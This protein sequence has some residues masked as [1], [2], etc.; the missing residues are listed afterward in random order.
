[1]GLYQIII[2]SEPLNALLFHKRG[3]LGSFPI[4]GCEEEIKALLL[5]LRGGGKVL[6][7]FTGVFGSSQIPSQF[8]YLIQEEVQ[9]V[10]GDSRIGDNLPEEVDVGSM[11][12]V[13]HHHGTSPDHL[14]LDGWGHLG[15]STISGGFW[16][17]FWV[18]FWDLEDCWWWGNLEF[19][20]HLSQFVPEFWVALLAPQ[21]G[22]D[23]P[24][25]E[26]D[27]FWL[28]EEEGDH[29]HSPNSQNLTGIQTPR[30]SVMCI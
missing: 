14:F 20:A 18:I 28:Q 27:K 2:R 5:F 6:G 21:A 30:N 25:A 22:W 4:L 12:L 19:W 17:Y 7:S 26:V 16:F 11:G 23:E 13:S 9:V 15:G 1:M 24:E 8:L 29:G 3:I 10:A